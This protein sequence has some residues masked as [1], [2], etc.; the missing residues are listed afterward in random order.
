MDKTMTG[1]KIQSHLVSR[2]CL[3]ASGRSL[4][5]WTPAPKQQKGV[6]EAFW[7]VWEVENDL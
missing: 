5:Q 1:K 7:A 6:P 3:C 2:D 4:I